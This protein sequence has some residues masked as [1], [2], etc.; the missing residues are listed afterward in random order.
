[1]PDLTPNPGLWWYFF[2]E[3]FDAFRGF[4]LGVFWLHM[5]AYSV[6]LCLRMRKLPLAA[7]VSLTGIIAVFQPY[8]NV[9]DAGTWLAGLSLFGHLLEGSSCALKQNIVITNM[10]A[11]IFCP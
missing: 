9:G 11:S 5:L 7:A 8:A 4:F 10:Q 1:M 6:P 3:M 2:I